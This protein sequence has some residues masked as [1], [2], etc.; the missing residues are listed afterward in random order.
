MEI[1]EIKKNTFRVYGDNKEIDEIIKNNIKNEYSLEDEIAILRKTINAL[2]NNK[3]IPK[4]FTNYN[5]YVEGVV[6]T[7]KKKKRIGV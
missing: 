1:E 7:N 2:A 6:N 3:E 5:N 4:E